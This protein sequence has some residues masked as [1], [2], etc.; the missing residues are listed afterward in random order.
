MGDKHNIRDTFAEYLRSSMRSFTYAPRWLAPFKAVLLISGLLLLRTR[1]FK[2]YTPQI[3]TRQG[4]VLTGPPTA[5]ALN[6][7]LFYRDEFE[8][9]LTSLIESMVQPGE[10]CIDAGANV[11]YFTLLLAGRAGI[12]GHVWAIEASDRNV[13]R[14]K[15]NLAANNLTERVSVIDAA[16]TRSGESEIRFFVNR[17]NDMHSRLKLPGVTDVDYWLMGGGRSWREI[18][19]KTTTLIQAVGKA[20]LERVSMIKIDIE[21][22]ESEMVQEVL[23]YCTHPALK[24]V[25]EVK[26]SQIQSTLKP[27]WNAGFEFMDLQNDYSWLLHRQVLEP[28]PVTYEELCRRNRMVDILALRK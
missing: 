24:I 21:G 12:Q 6:A 22:A 3:R 14:L 18:K 17:R 28:K 8:P 7:V 19:V 4:H 25:V 9:V 26:P 11:G 10:L 13:M 5:S 1:W 2:K 20:S 27:L 16:Y 23:T 15:A